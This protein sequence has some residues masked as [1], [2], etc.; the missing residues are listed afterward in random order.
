MEEIAFQRF[1]SSKFTGRACPRNA[2][3]RLHV[4]SV[5]IFMLIML[6]I[7]MLVTFFEKIEIMKLV[8]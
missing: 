7:S 2:S 5:K 6:N 1:Q 8:E 4:D 3:I